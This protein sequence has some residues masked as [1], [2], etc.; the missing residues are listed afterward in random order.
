MPIIPD[1]QL[2]ERIP[3]NGAVFPITF[4]RD[5]LM[6]LRD[7]T[8]PLHWHPDFEIA[9]AELAPLDFQ[10]GLQHITL[11]PGE[12]IFV[13]GYV[14]H[15]IRQPGGRAP[16]PMPNI[17]FSGTLVASESSAVYQKYIHPIACCESLPCIVFRQDDGWHG[18][19]NRLVKGI[20]GEMQTRGLCYEMS[21][22]RGICAV[23]ELIFAH[24]GEIPRCEANHG[25]FNAR[26]RLHK[27]LS[28]IHGHYEK[29]IALN[30]IASAAH[31]SRSEA[32][33]CFRAFMGCSPVEALIQ[34]RLQMAQ[35]RLKDTTR[36]VQE[37]SSACGFN[38]VNYFCRRFRRMYGCTPGRMRVLGK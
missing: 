3:H 9:T 25:P 5:E 24:L 17:V 22:Q 8:G 15:A 11:Q 30:D 14:L 19:V 16:D 4:F 38:S 26:I 12:S 1:H 36:T 7:Y 37:I 23:L 6:A 13:N 33:R 10:I 18:E 2:R 28:Y 29:N 20:Y 35:R 31:V 34:Y 32:G 27:M 21:V